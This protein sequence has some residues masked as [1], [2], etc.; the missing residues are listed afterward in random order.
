V[1]D[2]SPLREAAGVCVSLV[3]WL[4]GGATLCLQ[5]AAACCGSS[6]FL[7]HGGGLYLMR[8]SFEGGGVSATSSGLA[9]RSCPQVV[10]TGSSGVLRKDTAILQGLMDGS[11]SHMD[12]VGNHQGS[13][14]ICG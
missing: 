5:A 2:L 1:V 11:G 12:L 10:P 4:C 9:N 3:T 7:I 13:E 8:L 6:L 14:G